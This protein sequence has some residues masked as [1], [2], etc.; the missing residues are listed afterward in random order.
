MQVRARKLSGLGSFVSVVRR[1]FKKAPV[2]QPQFID[3][4]IKKLW[5]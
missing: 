2:K 4:V 3:I 1:N 5:A